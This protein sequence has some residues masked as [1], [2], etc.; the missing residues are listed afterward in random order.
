MQQEEASDFVIATG[1]TVSLSYFIK[2]AFNYF[3]LDWK[4]HVISQP[5]LRRPSDIRIGAADPSKAKDILGWEAKINVDGVVDQM[6][7]AAVDL[8]KF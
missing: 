3:N 6:C 7:N 8:H 4:E 5:S 1:K 2:R